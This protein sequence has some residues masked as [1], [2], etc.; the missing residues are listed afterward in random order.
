MTDR[1]QMPRD[2]EV[3]GHILGVLFI[4]ALLY[5]AAPLCVKWYVSTHPKSEAAREVALMEGK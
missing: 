5:L 4:I 1:D 3:L 2:E